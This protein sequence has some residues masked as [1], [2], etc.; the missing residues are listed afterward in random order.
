MG[1]RMKTALICLTTL[2]SVLAGFPAAAQWVAVGRWGEPEDFRFVAPGH[3]MVWSPAR[4]TVEV[5]A[6]GDN[7]DGRLTFWCRQDASDGGIRFSHYF[8]DTLAPAGGEAAQTVALVVDGQ[9]FER[10]MTYDPAGRLWQTAGGL[11]QDFLDAFSWGTRLEVQTDTG[12]LVTRLGLNGSGTARG[13]LRRTCG[14]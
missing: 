9:R 13:A 8:G 12:A 5:S 4:D 6:E 7:H 2:V 3:W 11:G 14:L 10:R 1:C